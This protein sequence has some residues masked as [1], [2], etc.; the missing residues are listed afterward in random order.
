MIIIPDTDRRAA[1][2]AAE[3][4]ALALFDA[5]EAGRG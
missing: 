1:L 5:I 4:K 2:V 3:A